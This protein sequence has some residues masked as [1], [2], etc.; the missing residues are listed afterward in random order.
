MDLPVTV[1]SAQVRRAERFYTRLRMRTS[2]WL[3]R[4]GVG[5]RAR[6]YMLVLPDLF[7]LLI[8]LVR[9]PRVDRSLKAQLLL[10]SAYVVSPID[11]IP[12]I[13][14]PLGLADDTLALAF[15]L[16][17]VAALMGHT[18]EMVLCEHWEGGGDILDQ[19]RRIIATADHVLN[20]RVFSRLN[21]RFG[22]GN[23]SSN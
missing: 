12:D 6:D 4:R 11:L 15:A 22:S 19:L 1:D 2:R 5:S 16:S 18:G 20:R 7:A 9:D 23:P 10:A 21:Q 13:L 3:A 17:R 8:R 14:M